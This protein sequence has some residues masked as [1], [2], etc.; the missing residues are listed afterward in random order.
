MYNRVRVRG[1]LIIR[2]HLYLSS[3]FIQSAKF[4][5]AGEFSL[6]ERKLQGTPAHKNQLSPAYQP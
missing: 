1:I 4:Y 6:G 2:W 3:L 5:K